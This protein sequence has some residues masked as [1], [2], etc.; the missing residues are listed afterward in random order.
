MTT[1]IIGLVLTILFMAFFII[2]MLRPFLKEIGSETRRIAELLSQVSDMRI[3]L[4][5]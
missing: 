1:H 5:P 4:N 3:G 2:F